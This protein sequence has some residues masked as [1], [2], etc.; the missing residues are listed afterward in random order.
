M[1]KFFIALAFVVS[2]SISIMLVTLMNKR[3]DRY[4][5]AT[6]EFY[7]GGEVKKYEHVRI[8][9]MG[10]RWIRF[11]QKDGQQITLDGDHVIIYNTK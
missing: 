3:L 9:R 10:P 5:D 8:I 2:I 6:V 4:R 11:Q 1:P 7:S